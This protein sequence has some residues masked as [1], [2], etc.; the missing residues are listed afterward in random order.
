MKKSNKKKG[1][2]FKATFT[3]DT[4]EG[5]ECF[6][7]YGYKPS[8]DF[9][10]NVPVTCVAQSDEQEA[11]GDKQGDAEV[12]KPNKN[13][14]RAKDKDKQRRPKKKKLDKVPEDTTQ[15]K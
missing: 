9:V 13:G 2:I 12:P 5:A 14:R 8:W 7:N 1:L 3:E 10:K 11:A 6:V 15:D 4:P